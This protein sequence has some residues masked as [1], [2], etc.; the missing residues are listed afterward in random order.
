LGLTRV[1]GTDG[2]AAGALLGDV[3][4]VRSRAAG[5][6]RWLERIGRAVVRDA[7][8]RLGDVADAGRRPAL[9]GALCV[10]GARGGRAGAVLR[11]VAD[12]GR[13]ATWRAR[14]REVV[15]RTASASA[16][17]GLGDIADADRCAT[18]GARRR[19]RVRRATARGSRARLRDVARSRRGATQDARVSG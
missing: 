12:A 9:G 7:V 6:R 2:R 14:H 13:A 15:G 4:L 8:T 17:A 5:L 18:L 16:G 3:A 19:E 11:D 1:N 10:G